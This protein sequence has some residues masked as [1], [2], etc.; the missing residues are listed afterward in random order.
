MSSFDRKFNK[1]TF[2]SLDNF[3]LKPLFSSKL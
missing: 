1:E 2:I 3:G